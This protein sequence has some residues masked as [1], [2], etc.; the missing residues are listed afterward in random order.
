MYN[1]YEQYQ[2]ANVTSASPGTLIV[3]LYGELLRC[4]S[5][6]RDAQL[7]SDLATRYKHISKS[8]M[9]LTELMVSLNVDEGG[10]IA[11]NLVRLYEYISKR[12]LSA[13][14]ST[15]TEPF[16]EAI[17][18]LTPLRD[19]WETIAAPAKQEPELVE[20]GMAQPVVV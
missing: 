17:Q 15:T 9:I 11:W 18:L 1:G 6:A 13:S 3:L 12:I 4:L 20:V 10:D 5:V 7:Q 16:D 19:A 14:R 8:I 2:R